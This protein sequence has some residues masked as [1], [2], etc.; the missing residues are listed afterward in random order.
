MTS[1]RNLSFPRIEA[2]TTHAAVTMDALALLGVSESTNSFS[3]VAGLQNRMRSEF[4]SKVTEK[5][6]KHITDVFELQPSVVFDIPVTEPENDVLEN[7]ASVDPLLGGAQSSAAPTSVAGPGQPV[8]RINAIDT[9]TNQP[10][11]GNV[12]QQSVA[13]YIISV[14]S[15]IDGTNWVIRSMYRGDQ[16]WTFKYVCKDSWQAWTRQTAKTPPKVPIGAW[17]NKDGQ[18]PVNMGEYSLP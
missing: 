7:A 14:L 13:K 10:H 5:S 9:L 16:G 8:R 2:G 3:S 12:L 1:A 6:A 4:T 18:D 15:E 17:S 11:D